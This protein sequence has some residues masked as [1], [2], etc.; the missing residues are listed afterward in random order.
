M[1][2]TNHLP[3]DKHELVYIIWEDA[4]QQSSRADLETLKN[5]TIA[6]NENLG[7]VAH[8]NESRVILAHGK[9]TTG[10]IDY[11]TIPTKNIVERRVV[12]PKRVKKTKAKTEGD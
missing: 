2:R 4:C 12:I 5:I 11:F 1:A 7:W 8:E 3:F 6:T 9:S 10:E